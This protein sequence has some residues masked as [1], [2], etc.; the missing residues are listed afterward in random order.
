MHDLRDR[1]AA[2]LAPRYIVDR[3]LAAGG[4]G[5]VFLGR[6]PVLGR[7]VAI[8]VLPP[9]HAT[10]IAVERFLR[11]ARLLARLA[12]PH[13]V[14]ILEANQQGGLLWFVMPLIEGDTLAARL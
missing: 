5:V 14:T 13:I 12:H 3:E 1:L 10:A 4:M 7:E 8:K 9:E 2:A 6:D 11:E